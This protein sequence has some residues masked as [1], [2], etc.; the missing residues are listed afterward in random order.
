MP[1]SNLNVF[2]VNPMGYGTL[3]KYD[4]NIINNI[5][6]IELSYY[7]NMYSDHYDWNI[8]TYKIYR[9][10]SKK[11]FFKLL[12]YLKSQWHLYRKLSHR[13]SVIHFQWLKMPIL[14]LVF[15]RFLRGKK[16]H[17]ILTVHNILPH[18]SGNKFRRVFQKIY[19]EI[20]SIIVHTTNTK[21]EL[22]EEFGL[23]PNKI[24]VIPHGIF[25]IDEVD[26]GEMLKIKS[27]LIKYNNLQNKI[28]FGLLGR[29]GSYKGIE[30]VADTWEFLQNQN[31]KHLH[32]L[33]A[34]EGESASLEKLKK[35]K[36]TT[37]LHRALDDNE[38]NACLQLSDY[39]LLP[40]FK[41]SQSG[42]LLTA[43]SE[44]KRVIVSNVG[45]LTEPFQ[46]GKIGYILDSLSVESLSQTLLCA[47]QENEQYPDETIWDTIF[48][49]YDWENI[50]EMTR[51]IYVA[52][53]SK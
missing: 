32:L 19:R 15:I 48:N 33:I 45:G 52:A 14:D 22:I 53:L 29:I 2:F 46:F 51:K 28:I 49:Y 12:S 34:G 36:N 25:K 23:N 9:Y 47:A 44:R 26:S 38:F 1:K 13:G 41:I 42:V 3:G 31:I 6:N 5:R 35:M 18:N 11:G 43:L 21:L 16:Y 40:Y 20:D 50:G 37:I 8:P 17:V 10:S 7:C 30:L 4:F 39:I 24:H 27:N